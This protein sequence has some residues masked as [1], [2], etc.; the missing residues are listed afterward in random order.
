MIF[1]TTEIEGLVVIETKKFSDERGYFFESFHQEKFEAY[2]GRKVSF[3][4]SGWS[5]Y[6]CKPVDYLIGFQ[7]DFDLKKGANAYV[8]PVT[9]AAMFDYAQKQGAKTI[10]LMACSLT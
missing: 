8:N 2:I 10:I 7:S 6:V 4:G 3:A 5:N 9:V 1:H